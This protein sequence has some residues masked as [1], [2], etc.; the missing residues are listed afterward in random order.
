MRR[1]IFDS[2]SISAYHYPENTCGHVP[3]CSQFRFLTVKLNY[4]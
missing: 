4:I 2:L 3:K 1:E